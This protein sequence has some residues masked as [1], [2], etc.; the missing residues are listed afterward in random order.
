MK[1]L[2]LIGFT[3]ALGVIVGSFVSPLL[4]Q[5]QPAKPQYATCAIGEA[6]NAACSGTWI[7]FAGNTADLDESAWVVRVDSVSGQIW[8][9]NGKKLQLLQEAE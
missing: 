4:A 6:S 1:E 2:V 7:Y 5:S 9:K 3:L 8:Y